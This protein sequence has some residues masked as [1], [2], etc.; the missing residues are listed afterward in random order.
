ML[1]LC[2][3]PLAT[4]DAVNRTLP[5]SW[6]HTITSALLPTVVCSTVLSAKPCALSKLPCGG[7]YVS[8]GES[9]LRLGAQFRGASGNNVTAKGLCICAV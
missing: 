1:Q 8:T 9:G 6:R 5:R 2:I 4:D 3:V 7:E